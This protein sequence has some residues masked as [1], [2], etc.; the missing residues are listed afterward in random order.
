MRRPRQHSKDL[1]YHG[2][3]T[4]RT[5][6]S[7]RAQSAGYFPNIYELY[8]PTE[9]ESIKTETMVLNF[10]TV[11]QLGSVDGRGRTY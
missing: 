2:E 6:R 7:A 1:Y 3:T 10:K 11:E 4:T 8:T 5:I 9:E